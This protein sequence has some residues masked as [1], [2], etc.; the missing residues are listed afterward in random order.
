MYFALLFYAAH[1]HT[2]KWFLATYLSFQE[3]TLVSITFYV[4]LF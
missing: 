4:C 1:D 3:I 2:A